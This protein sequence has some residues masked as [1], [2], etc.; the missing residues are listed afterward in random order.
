MKKLAVLSVSMILTVGASHVFAQTLSIKNDVLIWSVNQL[1]DKAQSSTSDYTA[2]FITYG[3]TKIVWT[4]QNNYTNEFTVK[5]S[6]GSWDDPSTVGSIQYNVTLNGKSGTITL[7]RTSGGLQ[8]TTSLTDNGNN[9]MPY[10]FYVN[11]LNKQ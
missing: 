11:T 4:Q 2:Q 7:A 8:I 1:L 10:V 3:K 6:S 9:I 5:S